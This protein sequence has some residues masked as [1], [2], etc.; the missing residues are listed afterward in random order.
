MVTDTRMP[1]P[2][3]ADLLALPVPP[4]AWVVAHA[5]PRCEKK[6]MDFCLRNHI[7]GYLPLRKSI[8]TYGARKR[9]F[10]SP[11]FPGYAFCVAAPQE[12]TLLRQNQY[13]ANLLDV[14]DQAALAGQLRQ[15]QHALSIGDVVEVLPFLETGKQ[16]MVAGG[17][18]K[19]LEGI[20]QYLKSKTR[21]VINVDMINQSMAVEVD[22]AYLKPV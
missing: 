21:V 14:L 6:I 16:V 10:W 22:S 7:P 3:N 2:G 8:H 18:F 17:P 9:V 4:K 13:V 11:L 20:V 12:K 15:I 5:R 19:G 1:S